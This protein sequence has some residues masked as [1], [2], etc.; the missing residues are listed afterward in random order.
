LSQ[1]I[2][3]RVFGFFFQSEKISPFSL[4]W[5]RYSSEERIAT[6]TGE[7]P[8]IWFLSVPEP[9]NDA[10]TSTSFPNFSR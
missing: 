9:A 10:E 7:P 1:A 2:P 3:F 5:S 8:R 4:S 6:C